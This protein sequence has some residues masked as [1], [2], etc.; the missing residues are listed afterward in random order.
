MSATAIDMHVW[1]EEQ[2][3][4]VPKDVH[5]A[6]QVACH[7]MINQMHQAAEA[8]NTGRLLYL[9]QEL[10]WKISD[11]IAWEESKVPDHA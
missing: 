7:E 9:L 6:A 3:G 5:P 2:K 8:R 1:I 11:E 4:T 10:R